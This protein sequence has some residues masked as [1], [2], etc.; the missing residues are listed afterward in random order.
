M[1]I[2]D[3]ISDN[4]CKTTI[5]LEYQGFSRK[6]V[7]NGVKY[8]FFALFFYVIFFVGTIRPWHYNLSKI[9]IACFLASLAISI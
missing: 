8:S 7:K 5:S 4:P 6:G 2:I 3:K 1:R 9:D